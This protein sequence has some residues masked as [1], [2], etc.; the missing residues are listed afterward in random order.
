MIFESI[1]W[2]FVP[3]YVVKWWHKEQILNSLYAVKW[4]WVAEKSLSN[5]Q[6]I[7]T[8]DEI[9]RKKYIYLIIY[10]YK[11]PKLNN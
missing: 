5:C 7:I 4:C 6:K 1:F 11:L 2:K 10:H 3:K 9:I 8:N